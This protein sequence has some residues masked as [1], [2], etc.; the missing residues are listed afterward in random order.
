M[1]TLLQISMAVIT[2]FVF[3]TC[4]KDLPPKPAN[5]NELYSIGNNN[6]VL[7]EIPCDSLLQNNVFTTSSY[8]D[9]YTTF[10]VYNPSGWDHFDTYELI[11]DHYSSSVSITV[12]V[13]DKPNSLTGRKR[14]NI[15]PNNYAGGNNAKI[16]MSLGYGTSCG[17][18]EDDYIYIDFSENK[19]TVSMCDIKLAYGSTSIIRVSGR[20]I[21]NSN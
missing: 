12:E 2:I 8:I 19:M 13:A 11:F 4:K 14:Y 1:K 5:Y 18:S 16:F 9:G 7:L 15:S 21:Y 3:T 17:P 20:L 6:P 10:N